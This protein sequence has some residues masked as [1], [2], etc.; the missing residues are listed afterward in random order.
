MSKKLP[1]VH[2]FIGLD[3][4]K[5]GKLKGPLIS[6]VS[7]VYATLRKY[8]VCAAAGDHGSIT[9]WLDDVGWCHVGFYRHMAR[10]AEQTFP[11]K[12]HAY[13]WLIEW[14]PKMRERP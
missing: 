8:R 2:E 10:V 4:V 3:G 9:V 13:A 12:T 11:R 5:G 6:S 7:G 1:D 14:W